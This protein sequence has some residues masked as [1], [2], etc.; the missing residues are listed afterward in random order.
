MAFSSVRF[1]RRTSP[2]AAAPGRPL[3][4]VSVRAD[5]F[6][7]GDGGGALRARRALRWWSAVDRLRL[8]STSRAHI[9]AVYRRV[10][11]DARRPVRDDSPRVR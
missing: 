5:G 7:L 8:L 9:V 4:A 3:Y 10:G 6:S 11:G 1:R 2:A